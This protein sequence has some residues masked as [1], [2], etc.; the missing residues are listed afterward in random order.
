[1]T[2]ASRH[3]FAPQDIAQ[4]RRQ[5][6]ASGVIRLL[7]EKPR[8]PLPQNVPPVQDEPRQPTTGPA[9]SPHQG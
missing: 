2:N 8:T 9:K 1:M 3:P 7:P 6:L 4:K 5:L